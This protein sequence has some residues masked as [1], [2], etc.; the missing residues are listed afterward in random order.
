MIFILISLGCATGHFGIY[1]LWLRHAR[2]LQTE[3][4]IFAYHAASYFLLTGALGITGCVLDRSEA[5]VGTLFAGGMHGLYSL[6]FLELW[7]LTQGSYSL[8]ILAHI[9]QAGGSVTPGELI[10]LQT[11]GA[12]K[13]SSRSADLCRLG[14]VRPDGAL[15]LPGR[16]AGLPLRTILWLS[17]GRTMN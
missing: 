6:S 4:G 15:T 17:H 1:A 16:L 12:T 8:G 14:L 2:R 10:R 13:K 7:S 5:W 11:V 9:A 3:S